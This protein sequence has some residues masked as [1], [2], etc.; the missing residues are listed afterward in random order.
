M[1][2]VLVLDTVA[3]TDMQVNLLGTDQ[4]RRVRTGI[5]K[6]IPVGMTADSQIMDQAMEATLAVVPSGSTYPSR[7]GWF[8]TRLHVYP[9]ISPSIARVELIYETLTFGG[10]VPSSYV[11]RNRSYLLNSYT[12]MLP[13]TRQ[14]L[15][16][17]YDDG[18]GLIIPADTCKIPFGR[19]CKAISITAIQYGTIVDYSDYVGCVNIDQWQG[20]ARGF[21]RLDSFETE[22]SKYA[23]YTGI[24]AVAVTKVV[25][26]WSESEI[27]R[28]SRTHR[29]ATV[30]DAEITLMNAEP[31]S[32]GIIWPKP[33]VTGKGVLRAGLYY[34]APFS[35]IF[36]FN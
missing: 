9:T 12:S 10:A 18:A 14:P 13:G 7:S 30:P 16:L 31:Y 32:F 3:G 15:R 11:I 28:D 35:V 6:N 20:K 26:D 25:E 24:S 23:G 19:P 5:V 33:G 22:Q 29:F 1:A 21:W 17:G 2:A 27:L 8:F 4:S 34:M 36:G